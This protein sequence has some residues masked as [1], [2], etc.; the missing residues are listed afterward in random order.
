MRNAQA[1]APVKPHPSLKHSPLSACL[2]VFGA[3]LTSCAV[4]LTPE[5]AGGEHQAAD[6]GTDS[7]EP[8]SQTSNARGTNH[9][10]FYTYWKDN[11]SV[12]MTLPSQ[13]LSAGEEA[14]SFAV[15]WVSGT[16]NFVGG[17]GWNPGSSSRTVQYACGAWS[18]G[19]SNAYLAFYGWTTEPLVEYYVVDSWGSWRPPGGT[20]AGR[21]TSDGGTYDLYRMTRSNAPNITGVGQTFEQYWSV[22]TSKRTAPIDA[23]TITFANHVE[24]WAAQGWHLGAHDYQ[25]LATEVF[26]PSSSGSSD[27]TL[28]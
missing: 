17:K 11:G 22:R 15:S 21:V 24:A 3:A 12:T 7:A 2:F 6:A 18:T 8:I 1:V 28:R 20:P 13:P 9:D 14:G 16:Y 4:D 19:S 5:L 10:F 23:A 27:C 25:V 26:N